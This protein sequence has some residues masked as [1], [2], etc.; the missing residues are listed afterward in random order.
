MILLTWVT[1]INLIERKKNTVWLSPYR[2]N[3][4]IIVIIIILE[5]AI[6]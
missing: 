5:I 3:I 2:D 6:K 4:I 1:S